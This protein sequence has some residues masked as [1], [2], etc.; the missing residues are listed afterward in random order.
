MGLTRINNQALTDVTSAGLPT[1][2]GS[3]I[4]VKH[5]SSTT[6]T[7]AFTSDTWVDAT[8][9]SVTITP[10]SASSKFYITAS[11]GSLNSNN[12]YIGFQIVR[13]STV[14]QRNWTYHNQ[15]VTWDGCLNAALSAVDEPATT[16]AITYKVQ[17]YADIGTSNFYFNYGGISNSSKA[18]ITVME[19][20]G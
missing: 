19:I 17:I 6:Q 12:N 4:Q 10:T 11:A 15:A 5:A 1:K 16:S 7:N 20:A 13:G 8:G 2:S 14:V 3:V 9:F 18:G